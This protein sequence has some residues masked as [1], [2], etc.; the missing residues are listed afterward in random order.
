MRPEAAALAVEDDCVEGGC[1]EGGMSFAEFTPV[2]HAASISAQ[3]MIVRTEDG[4]IC[5]SLLST[6][7]L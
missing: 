2:R 1:V 7:M 5:L 3:P 4:M 6:L